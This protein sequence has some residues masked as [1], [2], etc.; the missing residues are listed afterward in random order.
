[1]VRVWE[2]DT[3]TYPQN[4]VIS[5]YNKKQ[6]GEINTS[7]E[8]I[9][10]MLDLFPKSFYTDPTLRWLDPCCGCGYFTIVLFHRLFIGLENVI[11]DPEKRKKHI[12]SN[13]IFM[14]EINKEN[15][16]TLKELFGE[17]SNIIN[18][19]FLST[20]KKQLADL[21]GIF[22]NLD[23]KNGFDAII[24]NPP[25]NS[26]GSIKVP[27]NKTDKKTGDGK[28]VWRDFVK[29]AISLLCDKHDNPGYLSF[30]IPSIWMKPDKERMYHFLTQYKIDKIHCFTNTETNRMF[31]GEA[32][33]PTCYFLLQNSL[34]GDSEIAENKTATETDS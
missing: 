12:I 29:M 26:M 14:I 22:G 24:G 20:T 5:E 31:H 25:Y 33:T 10:N 7:F 17:D 23:K 2:I 21:W 3:E 15:Y 6:F 16:N 11:Q 18:F 30:I 32:Q 28:T 19:D 4:F 13:M 34:W 27:T 9:N 1:M 8:L